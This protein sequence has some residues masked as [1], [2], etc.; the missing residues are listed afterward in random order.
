MQKIKKS[1]SLPVI[2]RIPLSTGILQTSVFV[3]RRYAKPFSSIPANLIPNTLHRRIL[4]ACLCFTHHSHS[5]AC[6]S[7]MVMRCRS[8]CISFRVIFRLHVSLSVCLSVTHHRSVCISLRVIIC[9]SVCISF[10]V[11]LF[12]V[13]WSYRFEWPRAWN[14]TKWRIPCFFCIS[15]GSTPHSFQLHRQLLYLCTKRRKNKWERDTM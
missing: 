8:V 13:R 5:S 2:V 15:F 12:A 7:L 1:V 10:Y 4:S 6:I 3:H 9:R 11:P 14:M